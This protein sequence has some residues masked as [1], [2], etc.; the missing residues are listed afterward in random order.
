VRRLLPAVLLAA[1]AVLGLLAGA[2]PAGAAIPADTIPA[3][4]YALGDSVMLGARWALERQG[5]GRVDAVKSR[6]AYAGPAILRRMGARLPR[7][8]V[9]HLGTNGTFPMSTCRAMVDIAG[10][11][12]HVFLVT[13]HVRR[14]WT[15]G[16]NA[17]IR[18]CAQAYGSDRVSVIDWDW[19]ASRHP[20]WLYSDGMH[21]KPT[22]AKA[23]ARIIA[24]AVD[25]QG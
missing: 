4:R 17:T 8:V 13:D 24:D 20:S 15:K 21:L 18:R 22:G 5:F 6:Q 1:C 10:A 3:G 19:A 16:N 14:S 25:R 12:R 11:N 7:D 2:V 9:I 23:Y